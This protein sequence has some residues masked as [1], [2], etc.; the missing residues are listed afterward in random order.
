MHIDGYFIVFFD[1]T[2]AQGA[3]EGHKF[4]TENG[5]IRIERNLKIHHKRPSFACCTSNITIQYSKIFRETSPTFKRNGHNKRLCKL[6][7]VDTFLDVFPTGILT[8]SGAQINSIIINAIP[9]Q[10][11]VHTG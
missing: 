5:E 3:S 2:P 6:R 11:E 7:D 9:T 10:K 4:H 1:L 8:H